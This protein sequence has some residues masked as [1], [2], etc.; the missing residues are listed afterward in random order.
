[1][2]RASNRKIGRPALPVSTRL[3]GKELSVTANPARSWPQATCQTPVDLSIG[4]L[5]S[6][7]ATLLPF[8]YR[9]KAHEIEQMERFL[10]CDERAAMNSYQALDID[11]RV[12][13]VL[14]NTPLF[15]LHNDLPQQP[16]VLMS[17]G[18]VSLVIYSSRLR[19]DEPASMER[20]TTIPS[21]TCRRVSREA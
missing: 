6:D 7:S 4:T 16:Y 1:M 5:S 9:S 21:L 15:D 19:A 12:K 17:I 20:Y 10:F 18:T 3:Y 2:I 14:K 13:Q 11:P 8:F